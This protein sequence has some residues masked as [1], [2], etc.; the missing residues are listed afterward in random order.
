MLKKIEN[1]TDFFIKSWFLT[2]LC[3]EKSLWQSFKNKKMR[4][5][6]R[7]IFRWLRRGVLNFFCRPCFHGESC[8]TNGCKMDATLKMIKSV[9]FVL[10]ISPRK[11]S[12][13]EKWSIP[14]RIRRKI[15][16]KCHLN[17]FYFW[18]FVTEIFR[19]KVMI[20]IMNLSKSWYNFLLMKLWFLT[21]LCGEKSLWQSFKNEKSEMTVSKDFPLASSWCTSFF[22]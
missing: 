16:R 14:Q 22:L 2:L 4:W 1:C 5:Q 19:H 12:L 8:K 6:F 20:K 3:D 18:N 11:H 9:H 17:F 21:L 15:L 7:R 10:Q 13:Q